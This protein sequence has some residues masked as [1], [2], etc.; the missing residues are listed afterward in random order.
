MGKGGLCLQGAVVVPPEEEEQTDVGEE[1]GEWLKLILDTAII[2]IYMK[3][4]PRAAPWTQ[5]EH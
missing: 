1:E 3:S 4:F 2:N 5:P